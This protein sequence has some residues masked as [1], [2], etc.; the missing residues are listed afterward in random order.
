MHAFDRDFGEKKISE[1]KKSLKEFKKKNEC[2]K[3]CWFYP[4]VH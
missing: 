3:F 4:V 2:C 1:V